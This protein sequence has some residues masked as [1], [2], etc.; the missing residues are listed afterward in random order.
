MVYNKLYIY[1]S[2]IVSEFLFSS[3]YTH[4]DQYHFAYSV[5]IR[6]N[7]F[8]FVSE[9]NNTFGPSKIPNHHF[10]ICVLKQLF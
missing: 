6:K 3:I 4:F 1:L 9:V 7:P 2:K 5:A 8:N 10:I